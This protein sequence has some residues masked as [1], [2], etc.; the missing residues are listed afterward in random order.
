MTVLASLFIK[1]SRINQ[2][3]LLSDWNM[4]ETLNCPGRFEATLPSEA[5]LTGEEAT[6][7]A[8][9]AE[10]VALARAAVEVAKDAAQMKGNDSPVKLDRSENFPSEADI[11]LLERVRLAEMES[12]GA[13]NNST[14]PETKLQEEN[15]TPNPSRDEGISSLLHYELD[16]QQMQD[17]KCITV[18]S[19]RQTERR[20]RRARAAAKTANR[21]V[22][23]KSESY[24]KKKRTAVQEVD[25]SDP[26]RYL[27][28]TTNT[29]KL[30]TASEELEL[31][32][33][34]QV[35]S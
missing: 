18:R 11:I 23:V 28:G 14:S 21:V 1:D 32:E 8:A 33:G 26:L 3:A 12:L 5:L 17:S 27:R 16:L 35:G 24:G 10:A 20:S 13:S 34:I 2:V 4:Y 22:P 31:S 7:A 25:Y 19:I 9:A 29:S 15:V 30:L 6:I